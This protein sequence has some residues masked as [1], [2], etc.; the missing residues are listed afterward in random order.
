MMQDQLERSKAETEGIM[1]MKGEVEGILE[2]LE[3][4]GLGEGLDTKRLPEK[5]ADEPQEA[6]QDVW[7][8]LQRQFG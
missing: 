5:I 1:R 3:K 7:E 2:G 8:E 4:V 6:G